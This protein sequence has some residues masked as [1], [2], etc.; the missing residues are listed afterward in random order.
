MYFPAIHITIFQNL[1]D[2]YVSVVL[3][4]AQ[5]QLGG[6]LSFKMVIRLLITYKEH[7]AHRYKG[8]TSLFS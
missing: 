6:S 5:R 2:T 1:I 8:S 4:W 3:P 7:R